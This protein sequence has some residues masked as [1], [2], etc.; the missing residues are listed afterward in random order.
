MPVY[1]LGL[2]LILIL[3]I[4]ALIGLKRGFVRSIAGLAE[5]IIAFFVANRFYTVGAELV[6][7]IP[8]LA[9]L[10]TDVDMPE[11]E[12]GTGFFEKLK[13]I[14]SHML[15][16]AING[17]DAEAE[18][19]AIIN[20][21]IADVVSKAIAFIVIFIV[22]LLL[23]KLIV[24]LIDK[25]CELPALKVANK[26]LGVLFGLFCGMFVTWFLANLFVNTLLP[27]FVDKWP[28]VFSLEMGETLI[29]KFFTRFSPVALIMYLVN[30]ISS[31]GVK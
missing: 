21:Y 1:I 5:Y 22:S 11:L 16:T 14:I 20:N 17:G 23:L 25:F 9:K 7:K 18:A 3:V 28:D 26:T 2:F 15:Q 19:N 31:I 29:V 10:K 13:A 6:V 4:S 12:E 30:L 27:I 8:F 24:F